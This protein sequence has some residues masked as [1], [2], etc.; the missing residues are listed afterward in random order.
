MLEAQPSKPESNNCRDRVVALAN[1]FIGRAPNPSLLTCHSSLRAAMV[2]YD[3][4]ARKALSKE[5][6][7]LPADHSVQ[8][9]IAKFLADH[10]IVT[11]AAFADLADDRNQ[12]VTIVAQPTGLDH[13]NAISMQPL[14]SAWRTADANRKA[15]LEAKSKG[16]E[17]DQDI[18]LTAEQRVRLDDDVHKHFNFMWP[19]SLQPD[20]AILGRL[21]RF[22]GKRYRYTPRLPEVRSLLEKPDQGNNIL[23]KITSQAG[24]IAGL[25]TAEAEDVAVQGLWQFKHRHLLCMLAYAHAAA[26][27]WDKASLTQ[28][29]EYHDWVMAKAMEGKGRQRIP[30]HNLVEA[31]FAMRSKWMMSYV[32]E[33]DPQWTLTKAIGYHMANSSY[34]FSGLLPGF[35][36]LGAG[37][38]DAAKRL[39]DFSPDRAPA[40]RQRG[41]QPPK[42]ERKGA[43]PFKLETKS[44]EG[45]TI[46]MF[47]NKDK[48][49]RGDFCTFAHACDYPKCHQK[50]MRVGNHEA[51]R[52]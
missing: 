36:S 25:S 27:E 43:E 45:A 50:H 19:I 18:R 11:V 2:S 48:C 23:L 37:G 28:L 8:N 31:D 24:R 29:L 15:D 16:H 20:D 7:D 42:Q 21:R 22:Y 1:L 5:L 47:F 39:R 17:P 41:G 12:I 30:I 13:Q 26:P 40:K 32:S 49:K 33:Q 44:K 38:D 52:R 51:P 4:D 35:T 3:A 6:H 14:R 10:K 46:C 9:E 34:I